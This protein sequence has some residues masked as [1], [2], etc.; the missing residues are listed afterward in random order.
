[1]EPALPGLC[2]Q[3]GADVA[4]LQGVKRQMYLLRGAVFA[5]DMVVKGTLAELAT[6]PLYEDIGAKMHGVLLRAL[7]LAAAA[8]AGSS[9]ALAHMPLWGPCSG[10]HAPLLA[11]K[12][13]A[14]A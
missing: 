9:S 4:A 3:P 11:L 12:P 10:E 8:C 6:S 5:L 14:L 1:M 13:C 2:S 7:A